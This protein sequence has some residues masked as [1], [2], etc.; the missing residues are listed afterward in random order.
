M[1]SGRYLTSCL[2]TTYWSIGSLLCPLREET[3]TGVLEKQG[4]HADLQEGAAGESQ[5]TGIV[6]A[7]A[8]CLM[9]LNHLTE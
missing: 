3:E 9:P 1:C 4:W 8:R 5:N 2:H 6:C 7:Q